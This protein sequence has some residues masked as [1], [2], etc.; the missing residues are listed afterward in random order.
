MTEVQ[1]FADELT[2][3]LKE[4]QLERGAS[5]KVPRF[6]VVAKG[7]PDRHVRFT[8]RPTHPGGYGLLDD[9]KSPY[10]KVRVFEW[11]DEILGRVA[12]WV[13]S[14]I[15]NLSVWE[16]SNMLNAFL[17][18]SGCPGAAAVRKEIENEMRAEKAAIACMAEPEQKRVFYAAAVVN[19]AL[20]N[21]AISCPFCNAEKLR[22]VSDRIEC[23][24][25]VSWLGYEARWIRPK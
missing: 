4:R 20:S 3:V 1:K 24:C 16:V 10:D 19:R 18:R 5:G 11:D 6:L 2:G 22:A 13:D 23:G 9:G 17:E 7:L 12:D 14:F 8:I 25:G 15:S 21:G